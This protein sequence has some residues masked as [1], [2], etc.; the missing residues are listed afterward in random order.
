MGEVGAIV[1]GAS[2]NGALR[3][4][5]DEVFAADRAYNSKETISFVS[6]ALGASLLRTYRRALWFLYV[7]GD[8]PIS[9]HHKVM[10]VSET[11]W[12]A[13]YTS[14]LK[15]VGSNIVR[16]SEACVYRES[17]SGRIDALVH[18]NSSMFTSRCFT[19]VLCDTFRTATAAQ[20]LDAAMTV[21]DSDAL[22]VESPRRPTRSISGVVTGT[23]GKAK[24]DQVL[25]RDVLMTFLQSEDPIW[26]LLR[27]SRFTSRTG[28]GF[29]ATV[30]R[31]YVPSIRSM[32]WLIHG[33]NLIQD[34]QLLNPD[35][36][37]ER[38]QISGK[39]D[40]VI[41]TLGL[42]LGGIPRPSSRGALA[43]RLTAISA[44]RI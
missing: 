18:K 17:C 23:T 28:H 36:D 40:D 11:G 9:C 10:D 30:A 12:R 38:Q 20:K 32:A 5:P 22:L 31:D 19:I 24:V 4:M 35:V 6:D 21:F 14:R 8:G 27:A 34:R 44:C 15:A 37:E 3:P 1:A 7:F 39:R 33:K 26:F 13:I 41:R 2:T 43:T 29:I 42:K 25:A 16:G